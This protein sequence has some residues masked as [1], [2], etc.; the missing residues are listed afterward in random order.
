MRGAH[1][2]PVNCEYPLRII[3]AD[4]GSTTMPEL[5]FED[6]KDHPR[7]CGEHY[8]QRSW[9]VWSG[10]SSPRMRGALPQVFD[11]LFEQRIIPADAGSTDSQSIRCQ[12]FQDH[13]RGCGE[14]TSTTSAKPYIPGSSPRMRGARYEPHYREGVTG[15]IPADAGSTAR[16]GSSC[17][18]H[19]DH[20]R[21]CGEHWVHLKRFSTWLGSSP[22]MR[23]ALTQSIRT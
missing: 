14:H 17:S 6:P 16:A 19:P 10:G 7:G 12:L 11:R 4:A 9:Y 23:G 5:Y 22:R 1:R 20:P 21:G 18:T 13:P 3:P 2:Q 15:I 8:W